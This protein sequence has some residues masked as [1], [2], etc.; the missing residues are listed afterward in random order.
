MAVGY[1]SLALLIGIATILGIVAEKTR[2]P[3]V[4]AY[5]IAGLIVG[6]VGF[7][8]ISETEMTSLF[9]ELGLVF[10]LFLIGLEINLEEVKDVLKPTIGIAVIQMILVFLLGL[11]T[12]YSLGFDLTTAVFIG[13]AAM[14]SS[15]ALVVKLLTNLDEAS[16]LPGR[17]DIGILLVQ[18]VAVVLILALLTVQST[19]PTQ[20]AL[21]LGEIFVMISFI[22]AISLLS[23]KYLFSRILKKLSGNK[24]AFFTHGVAWAFL[25]I[26]LS[27]YFN[28]SLEI[29]AFI[30]GVGLAQIPY[31]RELQERVRPMTDLFM[32][33]FF[34]NF[35]LGITGG[36][37]QAYLLE[38]IIAS[39]ILIIGKF[40]IFF[41][42]VDRFKFTPETSFKTAMNMT[43]VSE[44]GLILISLAITQGY[45]AQDVSGFISIVT[46]LTMGVSAYTIRFKDEIHEKVE[47]LLNFFEGEE[48]TD[49]E[50][51]KLENHVV[52]IGYDQIAR[53]ACETL[54]EEYEILVID[55]NSENTAELSRSN[56]EYIYGDFKHGE[57]REAAKIP[58]AAFIISLSPEKAVNDR[59]LEEKDRDSTAIVKAD[60]IEHAVDLYDMGADY[61]IVK[62][63]LTGN[64]LSEYLELYLEDRELFIKE[65]EAEMKELRGDKPSQN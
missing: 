60:S 33:I 12:T 21:K 43:Q 22:A 62:N 64:R 15:T 24:A 50:I 35:G 34:L 49:I 17:L 47:H 38:A 10:L 63:L 2:Q 18:D 14:F 46:I 42:V 45:I 6:P 56:Y 52:V 8:L 40:A 32:A 25:F 16:T 23:S 26:S 5:I 41:L 29:G 55:R 53:K 51:R 9:S 61:V 36:S 65:V 57:I 20:I 58:E 4:M 19:S 39:I 28:L 44:F 30:A 1:E 11:A 31:S 27:Q 37:L 3:K 7:N 48:K 54:Q 13:A 59:I